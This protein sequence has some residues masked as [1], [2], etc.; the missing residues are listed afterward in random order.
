MLLAALGSAYLAWRTGR[1]APA[2]ERAA[3]AV[4][5]VSAVAGAIHTASIRLMALDLEPRVVTY[6]ADSPGRFQAPEPGLP[7]IEL[8]DQGLDE[9]WA[10]RA[11]DGRYDF[12]VLGGA[13]GLVLVDLEPLYER[14]RAFYAGRP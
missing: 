1:G 6:T 3:V 5:L 2:L 10:A 12:R 7:A 9:F 13:H 4:L 14:T 11:P 8:A